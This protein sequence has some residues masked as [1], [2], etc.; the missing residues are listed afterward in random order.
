MSYVPTPLCLGTDV[1][2]VFCYLKDQNIP[3]I[4]ECELFQC[5]RAKLFQPAQAANQSQV[6]GSTGKHSTMLL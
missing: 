3:Y 1:K 4:S 5:Q 2:V 6:T